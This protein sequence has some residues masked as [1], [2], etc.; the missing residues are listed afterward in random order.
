MS[1]KHTAMLARPTIKKKEGFS[2]RIDMINLKS[3]DHIRGSL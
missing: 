2:I 1:S 3:D